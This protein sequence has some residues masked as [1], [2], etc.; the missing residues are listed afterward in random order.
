MKMKLELVPVPVKD[1][2]RSMAFYTEKLGFALD[3]DV[4]PSPG[5]RVVQLTPP[6]SACSIVISTGLDELSEMTPGSIKGL[7]LVVNAIS[8]RLGRSCS[9][10]AS[11]WA[12]YLRSAAA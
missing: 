9:A 5:V 12:I 11:Q 6:G 2:D 3:V 7:H 10:A 1:I 8:P 4:S